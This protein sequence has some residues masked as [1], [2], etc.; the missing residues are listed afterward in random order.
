LEYA[1]KLG[2]AYVLNVKKGDPVAKIKELTG[3]RGRLHRSGRAAGD[4]QAMLR[5]R[6]HGRRDGQSAADGGVTLPSATLF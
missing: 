6:V 5:R 3:G 1:K 4:G 2:A